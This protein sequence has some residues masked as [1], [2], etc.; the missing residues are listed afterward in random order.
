MVRTKFAWTHGH[1]GNELGDTQR[2]VIQLADQMGLKHQT[3]EPDDITTDLIVSVPD[4]KL[5]P[6]LDALQVGGYEIEQS[7]VCDNDVQKLAFGKYTGLAAVVAP[8]PLAEWEMAEWEMDKLGLFL[9]HRRQAFLSVLDERG[10]E[11]SEVQGKV[12]GHYLAILD[13]EY[14]EAGGFRE[15]RGY[16]DFTDAC[17]RYYEIVDE[18]GDDGEWHLYDCDEGGR[19]IEYTVKSIICLKGLAMVPMNEG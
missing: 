6:F 17:Q 7:P 9:H 16:E 18:H 2:L 10:F 8:T 4:E 5:T 14:S 11:E 19:E 15:V 13:G 12:D 1:I 3:F